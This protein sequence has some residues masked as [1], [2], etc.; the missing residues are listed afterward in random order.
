MRLT[1]GIMGLALLVAPAAGHDQWLNG[2]EVDPVLKL[3]CCGPD[4]TKLVDSL[5]RLAA[6]G[7][8]IY[9]TDQPDIIIPFSRVQPSPDGHWWRSMANYEPALVRCVFGP[10]AY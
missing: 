8:G 5:V 9:F 7:G 1:L 10:Y 4:D 2:Y 6:N 3:I